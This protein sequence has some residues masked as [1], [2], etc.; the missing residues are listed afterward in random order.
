MPKV[1]RLLVTLILFGLFYQ[2]GAA[3][4]QERRVILAAPAELTENG[5]LKFVLPR[6]SLKNST[7]VTVVP[8][9]DATA[10]AVLSSAPDADGRAVFSGGGETYR[11]VVLSETEF[12]GRL[13]D[14]VRSD[15][16]QAAIAGFEIDGTAPFGPPAVRAV[17]PVALDLE[18]D[19]VSGETLSLS[20]CGRCHVVGEKNRLDGIGSSPSF[21]LMRTFEDWQNRFSAFYALRP[22]PA[23]TQITDVT[24]P[25]DPERPPA[26]APIELTIDEVENIVAYVARIV[27]ADL[28]APIQHQ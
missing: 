17:E 4:A 10:E 28:G 6:F 21:A 27:P 14:W 23:F 5:F 19:A 24:P 13:A 11:L 20:H 7:R 12:T 26:I 22:H 18:G 16:G 2:T 1:A 15:A 25:F 9:D 8:L 3:Q